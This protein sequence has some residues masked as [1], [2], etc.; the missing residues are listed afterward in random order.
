M[1]SVGLQTVLQMSNIGERAHQTA[2]THG[3]VVS[4]QFKEIIAK[5]NDLKKTEVQQTNQT[6]V[7]QIRPD[8]ERRHQQEQ[9]RE[10]EEREAKGKAETGEEHAEPEAPVKPFSMD[11]PQGRLLNIKV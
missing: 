10:R 8:E 7:V 4:D 2:L 6:D 3:A 9:E 11:A 1:Q 5:Q